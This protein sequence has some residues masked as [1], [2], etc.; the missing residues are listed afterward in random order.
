[1]FLTALCILDEM[2]SGP[3]H[4]VTYSDDVDN[5]NK[6][7]PDKGKKCPENKFFRDKV[8]EVS[9]YNNIHFGSI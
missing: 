1:M 7:F 6:F 3:T 2:F 8:K 4:T 5:K 9:E